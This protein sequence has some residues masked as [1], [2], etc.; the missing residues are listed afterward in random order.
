[1]LETL[2]YPDELRM[3]ALEPVE[4]VDVSD[5]EM[6]MAFTL[7]EMLEQPFEPANYRDEY[8]DALMEIINAKLEGQEVVEAEE[9]ATAKVIDL[10]SAL[11]AS[12]AA[13][14]AR[15]EAAPQPSGGR[16]RKAAAS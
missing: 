13:T 6:Q 2:F 3:P 1:M 16:R 14:K 9:P 5:A 8:R 7:I 11:K 10:M 4:P 15:Q 12:V